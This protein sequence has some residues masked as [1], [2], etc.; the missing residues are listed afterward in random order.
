M[1]LTVTSDS[2]EEAFKPLALFSNALERAANPLI[3][4]ESYGAVGRLMLV[5][6]AVEEDAQENLACCKTH[7]KTGT[8]KH[9]IT[10]ERVRYFSLA[11]PFNPKEIVEKDESEL[12]MRLIEKI[13]E[14]M[15]NPVVK[16]PKDFAYEELARK[17]RTPFQ[18]FGRMDLREEKAAG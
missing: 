15:E 10:G 14:V 1:H 9:P 11:V 2:S 17:L 6:V 8:Y 16:I 4:E 5:I 13:L 7:N 12:R 18:I 3:V